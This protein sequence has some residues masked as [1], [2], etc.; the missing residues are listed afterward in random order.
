MSMTKR[1]PTFLRFL[2]VL[3][4]GLAVAFG[5]LWYANPYY[6]EFMNNTLLR[7][8]YFIVAAIAALVIAL[9]LFFP[10]RKPLRLFKWIG[11]LLIMFV[12]V[13]LVFAVGAILGVQNDMMFHPGDNDT[14]AEAALLKMPQVEEV[15][16]KSD[17]TTYNGYMYRKA[18]VKAPTL[19]Y[20]GGNGELAA[21][22]MYGLAQY[23]LN[24]LLSANYHL[25]VV[26]YPGYG[27]SGGEPDEEAFK[28]MAR[29]TLE[30]AQGNEFVDKDKIVLMGWS[31][32]TGS[33]AYL[34]SEYEVAGV[35]LAA[36][37]YN[38][39]TLVNGFIHNQMHVRDTFYTNLPTFLV[40]NKFPSNDYAKKTDE[41][42]L[43]IAAKEDRMIPYEQAERL[44]REYKDAQFVLVEGGHTS[45]IYDPQPLQTILA[46]LNGL[47]GQTPA[48]A[49]TPVISTP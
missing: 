15:S 10:T 39:T 3:A 6:Q 45:V 21:T 12:V 5:L 41:K 35:V 18:D 1:R 46:F 26:D 27:K 4:I 37:F 25:L 28:D 20:F 13:V 36:P 42:V 34:A 48:P 2:I 19:I 44:S 32:G 31:L 47:L 9:F 43:I 22:R 11:R 38:G 30:F 33:A 8:H 7:N 29:A 16:V 40:S 49:E 14:T 24:E 17:K 23:G